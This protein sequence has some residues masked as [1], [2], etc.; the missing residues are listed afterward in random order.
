MFSINIT[1]LNFSPPQNATFATTITLQN[2]NLLLLLRR[3][4]NCW[5]KLP[6][7]KMQKHFKLSFPKCKKRN[8]NAKLNAMRNLRYNFGFD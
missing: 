3:F 7:S 4:C 8:T 5:T 6:F 1:N 2:S